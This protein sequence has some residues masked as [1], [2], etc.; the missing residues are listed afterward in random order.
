MKETREFGKM[1]F[2]REIHF[3]QSIK[4]CHTNTSAT[5]LSHVLRIS[6]CLTLFS[7]TVNDRVYVVVKTG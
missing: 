3:G 6:K 5:F 1:Y 2:T 7:S 4:K